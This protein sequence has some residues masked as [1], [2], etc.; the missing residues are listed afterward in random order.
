MKT[1]KLFIVI[2]ILLLLMVGC[3][4]S[5]AGTET[6]SQPP[7]P[8]A[9]TPTATFVMNPTDPPQEGP[10]IPATPAPTLEPPPPTPVPEPVTSDAPFGYGF[11][12]YSRDDYDEDTIWYLNST[13]DTQFMLGSHPRLSPNGQF[14]A[15]QRGGWVYGDIY[16]RDLQTGSDTLIFTNDNEIN[17]YD[18]TTDSGQII[19]DYNCSI[20]IMGIDGSN[21]REL[22]GNWPDDDTGTRCWNDGPAINPVDGRIAW[23]NITFGIGVANPDGG[24]PYWI[25]NTQADD[26]WAAWSPDGMWISFLREGNFFKVRPD[27]SELTQLTNFEVGIDWFSPAGAWGFNGQYIFAFG[28]SSGLEGLYA[29][30]ADGSGITKLTERTE[31]SFDFVGSVGN[32][33][34]P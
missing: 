29:I 10:T 25:P 11:V 18:W 4:K 2:V 20:Y 15:Y 34:A 13:G 22:I 19:F 9:D 21:S 28:T 5:A 26:Q 33:E 30:A 12:L 3:T 8:Q 27:G 24:S 1:N 14:I 23:D 16:V 31:S 17:F 32:R 6:E 7:P